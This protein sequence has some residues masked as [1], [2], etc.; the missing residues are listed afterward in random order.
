MNLQIF[1]GFLN[2]FIFVGDIY[3]FCVLKLY[4]I[5]DKSIEIADNNNL[6]DI[7]DKAIAEKSH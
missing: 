6:Y 3:Y 1:L 4:K 5:K 7:F 2:Q